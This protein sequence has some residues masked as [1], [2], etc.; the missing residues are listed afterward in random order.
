MV[1]FDA[2]GFSSSGLR[3]GRQRGAESL[4]EDWAAIARLDWTPLPGVQLGGSV[5]SGA[6]GQSQNVG[7]MDVPDAWTTLYELHGVYTGYNATVR[8]LWTQAFVN[9]AGELSRVLGL[10]TNAPV[11]SRME[12]TY[13]TLA[14]DVLPL[15]YPDSEMTLEPFF[16]F[17]YTNTQAKVPSGFTA[18]RTQDAYFWIMGLQFKPHPQV[19]LKL[20]YRLQDPRV[21]DDTNAVEI[22]M[23]FVF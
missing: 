5:F 2:T 17:E 19:V 18:D 4:A 3:G 11:A 20:D 8:A 7:G 23:G 10:A 15:L 13:V 14:Y 21:G 9:Q 12:G 16:Q 6:T 1:S 22:G